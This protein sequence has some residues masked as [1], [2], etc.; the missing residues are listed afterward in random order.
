MRF[1][2]HAVKQPLLGTGQKGKEEKKRKFKQQSNKQEACSHQFQNYY[3]RPKESIY[4]YTTSIQ[5]NVNLNVNRFLFRSSDLSFPLLKWELIFLTNK[6]EKYDL[7][8][9][10]C[11]QKELYVRRVN[12]INCGYCNKKYPQ[13]YLCHFFI[14]QPIHIRHASKR[15]IKYISR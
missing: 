13:K 1:F 6:I 8:M 3:C 7:S 14:C 10:T 15:I 12:T 5:P 11:M 2:P 4:W 9:K